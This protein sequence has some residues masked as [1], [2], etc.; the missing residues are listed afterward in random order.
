LKISAKNGASIRSFDD[1]RTLAPPKGRDRQW[2]DGRSAKEL[3]RAWCGGVTPCAPEALQ[4]L[5][6]PLVS[7]EQLAAAE[8]WPEHQVVIDDLPGEPPNVDLAVVADGREGRTAICIEAKADEPFGEDTLTL[9]HAAIV[10][11]ARDER[12]GAIDR[13]QR[14]AQSLLPT[15]AVGLPHLSDIRYQLL[16]ATAATLEFARLKSAAVAA[17]VIHEFAIEGC[18]DAR[19]M[20]RNAH[21]LGQ[22]VRRMTTGT[23]LSLASSDLVP[24]TLPSTK[25]EWQEIRLYIGKI[26]SSGVGVGG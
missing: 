14:L 3:A 24:V 7:P 15:W 22:F 4:K 5:L 25:R 8:G 12:T 9:L 16:T 1:W 23:R 2:K 11:I 18:V 6:S 13:L 19:K 17:L 20:A 26:T 10:K 21:D